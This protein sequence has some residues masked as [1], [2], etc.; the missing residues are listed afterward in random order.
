MSTRFCVF[1]L[2]SCCIVS[3]TYLYLVT[4]CSR[5]RATP[6]FLWALLSGFLFQIVSLKC[7]VYYYIVYISKVNEIKLNENENENETE[8]MLYLFTFN[9]VGFSLFLS[10][11][12]Y[13]FPVCN[14]RAAM[15]FSA[16]HPSGIAITW[17]SVKISA[18]KRIA[19]RCCSRFLLQFCFH[20]KD[21]PFL[22][23]HFHPIVESPI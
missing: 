18:M 15:A 20:P 21:S 11:Q 12:F 2:F 23:C 14:M 5:V 19:V 10:L 3:Q 9:P 8:C 7:S 1:A 17:Q 6:S 22:C 16:C 13:V 4:G